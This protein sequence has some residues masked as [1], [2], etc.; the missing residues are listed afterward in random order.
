MVL[1]NFFEFFQVDIA[2]QL[3]AIAVDETLRSDR[4][5]LHFGSILQFFSNFGA[6][7]N[8]HVF[9]R[10]VEI[11]A[12]SGRHHFLAHFGLAEEFLV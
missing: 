2:R 5:A 10:A 12:L 4:L 11:G 1:V 9:N 7:V 6:K 8:N 3:L